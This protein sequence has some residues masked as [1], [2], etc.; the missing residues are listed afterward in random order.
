MLI[1]SFLWD[2]LFR[3]I[4]AVVSSIPSRLLKFLLTTPFV[5]LIIILMWF[6][7][8]GTAIGAGQ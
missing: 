1:K 7:Q 5:F 6:S 2:V 8:C 3:F 4:W